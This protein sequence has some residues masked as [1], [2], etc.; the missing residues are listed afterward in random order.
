MFYV[1]NK[2]D[3]LKLTTLNHTNFKNSSSNSFLYFYFF[4]LRTSSFTRSFSLHL[5]TKTIHLRCRLPRPCR[6]SAIPSNALDFGLRA[7]AWQ[8]FLV[9]ISSFFYIFCTSVFCLLL[10]WPQT[11]LGSLLIGKI[12][13]VAGGL[14]F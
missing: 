14:V 9:L 2:S 8:Y 7:G 6:V 3:I 13:K 1:C 10:L 5:A 12:V 4:A 11:F